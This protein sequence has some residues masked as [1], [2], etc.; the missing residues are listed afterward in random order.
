MGEWPGQS[1][2]T[3]DNSDRRKLPV[4]GEKL[5]TK[6]FGLTLAELTPTL[7][8]TYKLEGQKGLVV[9]EINP[10]S[11]IADILNDRGFNALV[12]G[13]LIQRINR[14]N[15]ADQKTFGEIV[16]KLKIGDPVVLQVMAY[17]PQIRAPRMKIVQFT[18]K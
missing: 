17:D 3:T 16:S 8:V 4:D 14:V 18:V 9:K 1:T 6:P 12:P 10:K 13:D 5:E 15:V 11:F 2:S 7:A